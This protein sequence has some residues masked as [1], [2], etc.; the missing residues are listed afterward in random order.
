MQNRKFIEEIEPEI[1]R[2]HRNFLGP[3]HEHEKR[4]IISLMCELSLSVKV[5]R[6]I[7]C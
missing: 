1:S 2:G 3:D 6:F 7:I 4:E 5:Y